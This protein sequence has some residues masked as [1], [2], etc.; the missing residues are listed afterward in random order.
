MA[1]DDQAIT[2]T[3]L[4]DA[5]VD[6]VKVSGPYWFRADYTLAGNVITFDD[7]FS[8][9]IDI[10][11]VSYFKPDREAVFLDDTLCDNWFEGIESGA[12]AELMRM[13]GKPWTNLELSAVNQ[14]I[15]LHSVGEA[16]VRANK[17]NTQEVLV[18]KPRRFI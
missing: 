12:N 7:A 18:V 16:T 3:L 9:A 13:P 10:T 4:D 8:N 6:S 2:V 17:A 11:V 15:Y 1:V 5:V 14:K